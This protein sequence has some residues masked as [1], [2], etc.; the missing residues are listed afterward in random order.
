MKVWWKQFFCSHHW[1]AEEGSYRE[2][3]SPYRAICSQDNKEVDKYIRSGMYGFNEVITKYIRQCC[4]CE[5][6]EVRERYEE[7]TIP[8]SLQRAMSYPDIDDEP[9][10]LR[11][12][13]K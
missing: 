10:E 4:F 3:K 11:G 6:K 7:A 13:A 9:L 1:H 8:A 5:K 2:V 12:R